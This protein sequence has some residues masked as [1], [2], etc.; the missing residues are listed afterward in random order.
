[1]STKV[2]AVN[3]T[4]SYRYEWK[5]Q[6]GTRGDKDEAISAATVERYFGYQMASVRHM[7]MAYVLL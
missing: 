3:T 5:A 4:P 7:H 2:T 6:L 1:M